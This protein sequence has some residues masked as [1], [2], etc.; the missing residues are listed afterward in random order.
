MKTL[1]TQDTVQLRAASSPA[2][3]ASRRSWLKGLGALLGTGL[4]A[5]P[6]TLLARPAATAGSTAAP[7]AA[8][9]DEYIGLVKLLTGSTVPQGWALCDGRVLL[10]AEHPALFAV[11]GHTYGGDGRHTFALPDMRADMAAMVAA[12]NRPAGAVPLGQLCAIKMAN[13]PAT[14][15]AVAELRLMH[16]RRPRPIAA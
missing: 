11:L 3:P 10:T 2:S 14:T 8:G 6:S 13:A 9:G 1:V 4:L 7:A 12:A 5:S 16:L 15:T